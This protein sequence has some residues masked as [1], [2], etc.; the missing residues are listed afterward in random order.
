[1]ELSNFI[2]Y[3]IIAFMVLAIVL[4]IAFL[5]M[6]GVGFPNSGTHTGYVTA[7]EKSGLFQVD[8][9]YFKTNTTS[10]QEDKYCVKSD[11][12]DQLKKYQESSQQITIHFSR[13]WLM[14]LWVCDGG[15]DTQIV[16]IGNY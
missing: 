7:V 5:S 15:T 14:P 13:G 2:V 3:S 9:A 16:G 10:G 4:G 6:S 1:M 8:S 12:V 11:L